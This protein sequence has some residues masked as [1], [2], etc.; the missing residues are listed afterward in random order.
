MWM[1]SP[2]EVHSTLLT[3]GAGP[4]SLL[5]AAGAW[6]ALS[7]EYTEVAY[8]LAALLGAVQG[9]AWEGPSAEQYLAAHMP[10]LAWL[11]QAGIT[12]TE[13]AAQHEITAAAYTTALATM[14]TLAELAANHVLHGILVATNFFGINAVPIALN[15]ADYARMWIQAATTMA[16]YEAVSDAALASTPQAAPAPEIVQ[17]NQEGDQGDEVAHGGEVT[18]IDNVVAELLRVISGGRVIWDPAEGTLNG[19]RFEEYTNAADPYWWVARAIEFPKD[20][21]SFLQEL[22]T[23]PEEALQ[24]YFEL[25]FF[26]Y[27][28]HIVQILQAVNQAPLLLGVAFGAAVTNLGA[29]PGLA[30]LSAL[31]AIQPTAIPAVVAPPGAPAAPML[32]AAGMAPGVVTVAPAAPASTSAPATGTVT[33]AGTAPPPPAPAAAG[34]GYPFLVGGGPGLGF[35]SGMSSSA[36]ASASGVAKKKAPEPDSAAAEAGAAARARARRRRRAALHDHGDEFM[37]MNVDVDPDWGVPPNGEQE[38]SSAAS[39]QGAGYLGFAGTMSKEAG[40]AAAGMITLP[41]DEFGSGPKVPMIPGNWN[42]DEVE[43]E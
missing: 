3:S 29:V 39:D 19:M 34:F 43:A 32:P 13:A 33:S 11:T 22:I 15:E 27:P 36:S 1:A 30:G 2:P 37:D 35:G 5:A 26:D 28:E 4:G 38:L 20:F 7:T 9:G 16:A 8:E 41:E 21:E 17:E 14:P 6:S 12:S 23:N 42:L 18:P 40:G 24:S 31:A 10:Y 25:V